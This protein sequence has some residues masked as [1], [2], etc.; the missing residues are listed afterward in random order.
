MSS[1]RTCSGTK[2]SRD[3]PG[4]PKP[5]GHFFRHWPGSLE[6]SGRDTARADTH[7]SELFFIKVKSNGRSYYLT[8]LL[9][10]Y[11]AQYHIFA[12]VKYKLLQRVS[13][14]LRFCFR[15]RQ[16]LTGRCIRIGVSPLNKLLDGKRKSWKAIS[17]FHR[18]GDVGKRNEA[19]V[20]DVVYVWYRLWQY[21]E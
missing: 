7:K 11:L 19:A 8:Y 14:T 3:G 21:I 1:T 15:Q 4:F 5:A 6:C 16:E 10:F 18:L 20:N 9:R 2:I 13:T 12:I 17:K